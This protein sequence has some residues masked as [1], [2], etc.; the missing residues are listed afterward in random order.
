MRLRIREHKGLHGDALEGRDLKLAPGGIREIEFFTQTRQLIAGGRDPDAAGAR[1]GRGA[2][3]A[4]RE[5]LGARRRMGHPHRR[6]P[7]ASRGRTPAPDGRRPADPRAARHAEGFARLAAFMD[8]EGGRAPRRADGPH[9]ACG[10]GRGA[11]S[12]P[13]KARPEPALSAAA[14]EIV[15]RW[16]SYPALRSDRALRIFQRLRPELLR[17]LAALDRPEEA[18]AHLDGFLAGSP[19]ASSS[20][21]SSR[22]TPSSSTSSS[23][24]PRPPPAS[25]SYL[26]RN[27]QV[28][29]AV[30]GGDFF[31]PWPGR[32]ALEADLAR[33]LAP[34][35]DYERRSTPSALAEGMALPHRRPPPARAHDR[36]R[37]G[38]ARI[39]R[40][41]GRV[42]G[43]SGT[44][45]C[46]SSP[47][48]TGSRR[49]R[50]HGARHGLARRRT[51]HRDLGPRP[52]RH[53]RPRGRRGVRR[54]P[55]APGAHLLRPPH[56]GARHRAHRP[57]G[58]GAALR[59]RHAPAPLGP[60][61]PRRDLHLL[62]RDL[63][64]RGGL[65]LGAPR[66]HPR[67][68]RGRGRRP[69]ASGSRRSGA[70]SSPRRRDA[71]KIRADTADMRARL[72]AARPGQGALEAKHGPGRLLDIALLAQAGGAPRRCARPRTWPQLAAGQ[73]AL[74][75]SDADLETLVKTDRLMWRV[76][77]ATRLITG[78]TLD[79]EAMGAGGR[80][81]LL[82]EAEASDMA[83]LEAAPRGGG[84]G[85]RPH[86]LPR[87]R[88]GG[89]T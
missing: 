13:G 80:A 68:A 36:R 14:A 79:P 26:S 19:P 83:D 18:L 82:R 30:I 85:V 59:G 17:R 73:G 72:A 24:S 22:P 39:R 16:P 28:F 88:D 4:G 54:P 35:D 48:S 61:G 11:S 71:A 32:T 58:G 7:R 1:H 41:R 12:P 69:W 84:G 66:A 46:A 77:A 49:A 65:D 9:R 64:A 37:R 45:S 51:P 23:T 76:Q 50:R 40:S 56:A 52:H 25:P 43:A 55:P 33:R 3:S 44:R 38:G 89:M 67:A 75:L 29:D 10:A 70:T 62:L 2:R 15:A 53:L 63:P 31:S 27:S 87:A 21:R 74:G 20:S 57:D 86:H 34:V 78:G 6:L 60:A 8:R 42:L 47:A 5:G 81:L